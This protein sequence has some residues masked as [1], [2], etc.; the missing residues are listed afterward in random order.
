MKEKDEY[1]YEAHQFVFNKMIGKQYCVKCG[2]I[3]TTNEFSRWASDKGCHNEM[4]PSY[5]TARKRYTN[6]FL[7]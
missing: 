5:K 1:T 3:S 4:H 7:Y 2:L 6:K